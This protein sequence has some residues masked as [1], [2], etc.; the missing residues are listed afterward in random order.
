MD[1]IHL[2]EREKRYIINES[3]GDIFINGVHYFFKENYIDANEIVFEK[4]AMLVGIKCAHYEIVKIGNLMYYFSRDIGQRPLRSEKDGTYFSYLDNKYLTLDDIMQ[5]TGFLLLFD[6]TNRDRH[7]TDIWTALASVLPDSVSEIIYKI[8]RIYL[9]DIF[10]LMDD[11]HGNNLGLNFNNGMF[12]DVY[13]LDNEVALASTHPNYLTV[14]LDK[15]QECYPGPLANGLDKLDNW[16]I[17]KNI[18]E[19]EHFLRVSSPEFIDLFMEMFNI[20]TPDAL[21]RIYD[22]VESELETE[23]FFKEESLMFYSQNYEAIS[24]I[25]Y[26]RKL[27]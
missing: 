12:D 15:E 1:G 17:S 20:L 21:Q 27:R 14:S 18:A 25:V 3:R 10:I 7:I 26:N 13:I 9:F 8:I 4:F 11:R 2:T 19:L 23:F 24:Q 6:I 16:I 22:E 5:S